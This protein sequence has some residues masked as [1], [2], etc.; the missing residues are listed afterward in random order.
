MLRN[1][2][3]E[4]GFSMKDIDQVYNCVLYSMNAYINKENLKLV[5]QL[6]RMQ[7]RG[8]PINSEIIEQ[9]IAMTLQYKPDEK[10]EKA[11]I[12]EILQ[13]FT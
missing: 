12:S 11:P 9:F 3:I 5:R 2:M 10:T 6:N 13:I 1:K 7:R 4:Y 8:L